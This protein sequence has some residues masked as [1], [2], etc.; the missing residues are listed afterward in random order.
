MKPIEGGPKSLKLSRKEG[1]GTAPDGDETAAPGTGVTGVPGALLL[2]TAGA[3][4]IGLYDMSSV[5]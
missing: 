3:G 1:T 5:R 2:P 4:A